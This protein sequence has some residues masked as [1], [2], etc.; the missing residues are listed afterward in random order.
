MMEKENK[1]RD[2]SISGGL[3]FVYFAWAFTY[4]WLL[5]N[6]KYKA[7]LHPRFSPLLVIGAIICLLY[8]ASSF[9][10]NPSGHHHCCPVTS[11][12]RSI[13]LI[14]PLLFLLAVR[15]QSLGTHAFSRRSLHIVEDVVLLAESQN[16]LEKTVTESNPAKQ[17]E[18][19]ESSHQSLSS[20]QQGLKEPILKAENQETL[21]TDDSV[22]KASGKGVSKKQVSTKAYS[23]KRIL[24]DRLP[25]ADKPLQSEGI[26]SAIPLSGQ[27]M[28]ENV[29]LFSRLWYLNSKIDNFQGLPFV[30]E[31][32]VF[33]GKGLPKGYFLLYRWF[34]SC[35]AADAEPIGII[36]R[37]EEIENM[38]KL[39]WA[40]VKG[41]LRTQTIEGKSVPF[42]EAESTEKIPIPPPQ[43]RYLTY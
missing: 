20:N 13:L 1:A 8:L 16:K 9:L 34:I 35:C 41:Q 6:G 38:D 36:V 27:K 39:C 26:Q 14:L 11:W 37:S 2:H 17:P 42:I 25:T 5:V 33:T 31:G 18:S 40:R 22:R 29:S 30:I 21:P 3:S 23:A 28:P 43:E 10:P 7:F 12:I 4:L 15:G 19:R 24:V 32:E